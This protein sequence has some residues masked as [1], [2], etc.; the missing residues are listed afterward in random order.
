MGELV[1]DKLST[2]WLNGDRVLLNFKSDCDAKAQVANAIVT[3]ETDNIIDKCLGK[4]SLIFK[5]GENKNDH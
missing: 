5:K 2:I 3:E 4:K 1:K